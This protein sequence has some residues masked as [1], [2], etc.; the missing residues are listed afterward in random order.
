MEEL[1]SSGQVLCRGHAVG[2]GIGAGRVRLYRDYEE[3]IVGSDSS[4]P[5]VAAGE[6]IEELAPEERVFD[7]VTCS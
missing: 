4:G 6:S 5:R 1:E 7:P 2:G 3:V